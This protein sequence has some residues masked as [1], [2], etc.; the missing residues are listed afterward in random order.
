MKL[1]K[2][3][4]LTLILLGQTGV[5]TRTGG[6]E[7]RI[8]EAHN[9]ERQKLGVAPLSWDDG[10]ARE[11]QTWADHLSSSGQF[12]HSPNEAGKPLQGEN[13]WGGTPSSFTPEQMVGLWIS[14]KRNFTPGVFPHNSVTGNPADVSHYTQIVW[15]TTD[16]VGC[17]LSALGREEILVCRY[18]QP[19]NVVG[20]RALPR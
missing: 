8:L 18:A 14:E 11:A 3:V 10:L 17:A 2:Y 4:L 6:M 15:Q 13:L 1:H 7:Q 9:S 19:G 12:E 16:S 5:Q 20:Q